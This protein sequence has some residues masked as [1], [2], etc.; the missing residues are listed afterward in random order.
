M[1]VASKGLAQQTEKRRQTVRNCHLKK[2]KRSEII[3]K[4]IV[5]VGKVR[6]FLMGS[7]AVDSGFKIPDSGL[8]PNSKFKIQCSGARSPGLLI[9]DSGVNQKFRFVGQNLKDGVHRA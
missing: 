1:L 5:P 2:L 7:A 8:F 9:L 6:M 3:L 4:N